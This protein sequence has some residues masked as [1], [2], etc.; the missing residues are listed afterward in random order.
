MSPP[1]KYKKDLAPKLK[2][3]LVFVI[4][5]AQEKVYAEPDA[6]NL[7]GSIVSSSFTIEGS[8]SSEPK[9]PVNDAASKQI[10]SMYDLFIHY[11]VTGTLNTIVNYQQSLS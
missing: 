7:T 2:S 10:T 5:Y 9:Q 3:S 4:T 11:Q 6:S 1:W 8:I